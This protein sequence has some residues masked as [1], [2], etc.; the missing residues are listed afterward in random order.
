VLLLA[1]PALRTSRLTA[2]RHGFLA[3]SSALSWPWNKD[4][5]LATP[6]SLPPTFADLAL[7]LVDQ[8]KPVI[9]I[10][11]KDPMHRDDQAGASSVAPAKVGAQGFPS[12]VEAA[13]LGPRF[14]ED[15]GQ[16]SGR[17]T[18]AAPQNPVHREP[19]GP[20]RNGNPRGNPNLAPRCGA[21]TRRTGCPCR[22][23]AMRN[24]RCRLHGGKSTG[25]RTEEGRARIRA[26]RTRHGRYSAEGRAFQRNITDLLRRNRQLLTLARKPGPVNADPLRHLLTPNFGKHLV[27][28][29]ASPSGRPAVPRPESKNPMH[30]ESC[31]IAPHDRAACAWPF[32][33]TPEPHARQQNPLQQPAPRPRPGGQNPAPAADRPQLTRQTTPA[34]APSDAPM[35]HAILLARPRPRAP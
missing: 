19:R 33:T 14:R 23:P 26:A 34:T 13:A 29:E 9:R 10:W 4:R 16:G 17:P 18:I 28:R 20:L 24:G 27:Q 22:A 12:E 8:S 5:L 15:D 11:C 6:G 2:S 1:A 3:R 35:R 32:C 25:P 21:R 31:P 7:G 30:R